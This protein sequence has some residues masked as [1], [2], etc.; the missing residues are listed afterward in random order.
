MSFI[1]LSAVHI[2]PWLRIEKYV[3]DFPLIAALIIRYC[4]MSTWVNRRY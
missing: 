2:F 3:Y 4:R 1:R